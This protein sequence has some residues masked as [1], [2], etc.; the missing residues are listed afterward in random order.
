M[1]ETGLEDLMA[2]LGGRSDRGGKGIRVLLAGP[3]KSAT[4]TARL[5]AKMDKKE[6]FR[7]DLSQVVGKYAGETEKN[8]SRV[9]A[10]AEELDVVLLLDEAD[11]LLGRR[12][13]IKDAHDRYANQEV[14]YLLQRIEDF[15]GLVILATNFRGNIDPAFARRFDFLVNLSVRPPFHRPKPK[16]K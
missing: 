8:L 14:G 3:G 11:A 10:R 15:E 4:Q 16:K 12:T 7:I 13:D 9:F 2:Q 6:L 5:L 1:G